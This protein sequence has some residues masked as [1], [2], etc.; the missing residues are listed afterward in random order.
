[1]A[2]PDD[3][4]PDWIEESPEEARAM[5]RLLRQ[6]FPSLEINADPLRF[7][8]RLARDVREPESPAPALS[9]S[10][11][12]AL[13]ERA[14]AAVR[15]L[16]VR[17]S[18]AA[19]QARPQVAALLALTPAER[20]ARAQ[21]D[22]SLHELPV[23]AEL[24]RRAEE[25]GES[26]LVEIEERVLLALHL[27]QRAGVGEHRVR[28]LGDHLARGWLL[29]AEVALAR[30][31]LWRAD[32]AVGCACAQ[33]RTGS[34]DALL[35]FEVGL[36]WAFLDWASGQAA[37]TVA[38]LKVVGRVALSLQDWPRLAEAWIWKHLL[39][40]QLGKHSRAAL[41]WQCAQN[42]L[43]PEQAPQALKRQI[44]TVKRLGLFLAPSAPETDDD[45]P[46]AA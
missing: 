10:V 46:L 13:A 14:G 11:E 2:G 9:R 20:W 25:S 15:S 36:R 39:F 6:L 33:L 30:R 4:F 5:A 45:G 42:L 23:V 19:E 8:E 27:A 3:D 1:M 22:R 21:R 38:S 44:H 35:A 29:L 26:S 12:D 43:G 24:L 16:L 17:L 37:A 34:G 40:D 32:F 28:W 7:L 31:E 41:A 18:E